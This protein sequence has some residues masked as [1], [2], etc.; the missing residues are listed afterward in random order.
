MVM[1]RAYE[2]HWQWSKETNSDPRSDSACKLLVVAD[3]VRLV[4]RCSRL[5]FRLLRRREEGGNAIRD[6][7]AALAACALLI[8]TFGHCLP[9][10]RPK[11]KPRQLDDFVVCF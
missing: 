4:G 5:R 6:R 10:D 1:V 7:H 11:K 9:C 3:H 2:L 8:H